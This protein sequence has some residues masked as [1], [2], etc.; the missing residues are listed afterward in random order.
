MQYTG[1]PLPHLIHKPWTGILH[2]DDEIKFQPLFKDSFEKGEM[3]NAQYRVRRFDGQYRWFLGR[4]VPVRDCGG[5]IVQWF[6]TSTDIH[7][8]KLAELQLN[9]QVELELN[10]VRASPPFSCYTAISGAS[11]IVSCTFFFR[12]NSRSYFTQQ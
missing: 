11:I 8:Q 7:D 12:A 6:G 3:F 2:K 9:R 5:H 10:E 4:V 1:I